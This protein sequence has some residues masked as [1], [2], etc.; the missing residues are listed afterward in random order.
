MEEL[1][2]TIDSKL[3]VRCIY[4]YLSPLSLTFAQAMIAKNGLKMQHG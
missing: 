2:C 4:C 1:V 3:L